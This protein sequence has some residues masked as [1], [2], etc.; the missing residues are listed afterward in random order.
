VGPAFWDGFAKVE[1]ATAQ[2]R[3]IQFVILS[4]GV[5]AA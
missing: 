3:G 5:A 2:G 1:D 4:F